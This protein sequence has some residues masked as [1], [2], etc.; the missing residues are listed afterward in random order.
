VTEPGHGFVP[1][2]PSVR[3]IARDEAIRDRRVHGT[4]AGRIELE[5]TA[6][7]PIHVG[8]SSKPAQQRTVILR[9]V[10]FRSGPRIPGSSLTGVLRAR[11]EAITHSCAVALPKLRYDHD[12]RSSTG[13]KKARLL[14]SALSAAVAESSCTPQRACPACA[15][16]GRMSLRSR[17]TVTDLACAGDA[18]FN[19]ALI[20]ERLGSDLHHVGPARK[21]PSGS[22]FEVH[23]LHGRKF[24]LGR[25]PA[26]DNRRRIEVIPAGTVL[27]GQIRLFNVTPA[28]LGGLLAALGCDPPSALKVGGGKAH[29]LGRMH[30]KARY[31]LAGTGAPPLDPLEWRRQFVDSPDRW[32]D[33]ENHLVALHRG[34]C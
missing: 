19:V 2:P 3:R 14:A 1:L 18:R 11:Y 5:L 32:P 29:G 8:S 20:P 6:A 26:S 34:D 7:Q 16:F 31:Y 28:E 15:L 13:I 27:T 30:C 33:G 10:R 12:L 9:G 21:D 4:L 22:G 17:I 23:G 24:G 25:G